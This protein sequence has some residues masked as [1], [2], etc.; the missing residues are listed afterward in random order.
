MNVTLYLPGVMPLPLEE[1]EFTFSPTSD[2]IA[3]AATLLDCAPALVDV[4]ASGPEYLIYTVFDSEAE[5]NEP[6][7][8]AVWSLTGIPFDLKD[9][10]Q[11]LRGPVLVVSA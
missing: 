3:H 1:A 11:V 10:N 2:Q 5:V 7:M 9:E 8:W 6:S 4:L